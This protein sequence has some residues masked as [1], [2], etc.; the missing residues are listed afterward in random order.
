MREAVFTDAAKRARETGEGV[1]IYNNEKKS[2]IG[3]FLFL[4]DLGTG[5]IA[6]E[7]LNEILT[8]LNDL[9]NNLA[10]AT[11]LVTIFALFALWFISRKIVKPLSQLSRV[12]TNFSA[13]NFSTRS[14]IQSQ[15]EIGRL[16]QNFNHMASSLEKLYGSLED[17]VKKRTEELVNSLLE[18][19]EARAEWEDTFHAMSDSLFIY[20]EKELVRRLNKS[21]EDMIQKNEA[22]VR[23]YSLDSILPVLPAKTESGDY[24]SIVEVTDEQ[25]NQIYRIQHFM[26]HNAKAVPQGGVLVYRNIT[27]E[28]RREEEYQ[29]VQTQL[30][31]ASKLAAV[32]TLSAGVAHEFNNLIAGIRLHSDLALEFK[33]PDK[34][35]KA[36]KIGNDTT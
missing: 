26:K 6:E 36:L 28:R 15:D 19:E 20:D 27:D 14:E 8:S 21:A 25:N 5:L 30:I 23:G 34:M 9:R 7:T 1:G 24:P 12:V 17:Q 2:M 16:S 4:N 33:T 35:E 13:G 29:G 31:E 32:G 22:E 18:T 10:G 3:S 11:L